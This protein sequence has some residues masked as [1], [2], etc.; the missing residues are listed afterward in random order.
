MQM[1]ISRSLQDEEYFSTDLKFEIHDELR[2]QRRQPQH[3]QNF[4]DLV[5]ASRNNSHILHGDQNWMRGKFTSNADARS[6]CGS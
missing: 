4:V 5:Y 3:P 2:G 6:V 1:T